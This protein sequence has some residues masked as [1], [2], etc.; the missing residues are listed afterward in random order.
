MG[1]MP[2]F[3]YSERICN[4]WSDQAKRWKG[5]SC[6]GRRLQWRLSRHCGDLLFGRIDMENRYGPKKH[7]FWCYVGVVYTC[8]FDVQ[9][10]C[11]VYCLLQSNADSMCRFNVQIRFGDSMPCTTARTD[12]ENAHPISTSNLHIENACRSAVVC[13]AAQI[14]GL[15]YCTS[16]LHSIEAEGILHI[17]SSHWKRKCNR[18]LMHVKYV[19]ISNWACAWVCAGMILMTRYLVLTQIVIL[20]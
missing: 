18:P 9:I 14:G 11:A 6:R 8:V 15:F 7:G 19:K 3:D 5:G 13:S 10:G 1:E 17:Q 4:L 2:R 12:I 16:D 20:V